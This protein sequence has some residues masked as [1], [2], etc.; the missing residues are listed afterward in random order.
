MEGSRGKGISKPA[1]TNMAR[2]SPSNTDENELILIVKIKK[3][4]E[5]VFVDFGF[6][7]SGGDVGP[8]SKSVRV[9]QLIAYHKQWES[10]S[11][12]DKTSSDSETEKKTSDS[13][14][15]SSSSDLGDNKEG[16]VDEIDSDTSDVNDRGHQQ[17]AT[18]PNA[19]ISIESE[20]C[21]EGI[22]EGEWTWDDGKN[23]P[24]KDKMSDV[25]EPVRKPV[26]KFQQL[27]YFWDKLQ[28]NY[29][30]GVVRG[31][32]IP[33]P[34]QRFVNR[35]RPSVWYAIEPEGSTNKRL[36]N[37]TVNECDM[38]PLEWALWD[39]AKR[40]GSDPSTC[41]PNNVS[42]RPNPYQIKPPLLPLDCVGIDT[43]S[44]LSV[45]SE[46]SD[47]PFLDESK[48][49][50]ESISLRG[51]GGEQSA[52]GGRGPMLI[53]ALD[54]Q[55]RLIYLV[56][57]LGVF[58][59]QSACVQLR[60]LGQQRMKTFGFNL[61]QNK[62]GDG[63]D[64]LVYT[65]V[66]GENRT[67][68]IIPLTTLDGILMLK[69]MTLEFTQRQQEMI[70]QHVKSICKNE[71]NGGIDYLFHFQKGK[72]CPV[73]I[74]NEGKLDDRERN[75]LDHWR[76]AHRS[77]TGARHDE[78]CPACEQAKHKTGSFKR[79][80]EYVGNGV[81]TLTV[82]WRLYCDGYGGQQSMGEES[83]QGAKG[84]F[85]FVCPVSG[86][87]K[88]KLY[89][90]SKQYPAILYQV[91]QEVESE[92][93]AVREIYVDTFIVNISKAAEDVAAMFKVR[94]I[95]ISSGTPQE[96]AYAERAVQTLAQMSRALMAGAPHLPQF[97]WG[98][99][100]LYAGYLHKVLPQKGK[101]M[102]SPYEMTTMRPPNLETM[103][104]KVFGCACQYEP[105]NGAE[106]KRAPKTLW[107]WFVGVQW[108]MVLILRPSDKKVISVSRKKVHCHE[109]CY[110]KFDPT[111]QPRPL[112]TFT[113][114]TLV[115]N[116]IDVAIDEATEMDKKT[117]KK[118]K[119]DHHIPA[120]VPSVKS[121]SD[122]N[123]NAILNEQPLEPRGNQ[124]VERQDQDGLQ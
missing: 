62:D 7:P 1:K 105:H 26:F 124:S 42:R 4:T 27:V 68:A 35:R 64:Y 117:L 52:V 77:I 86:S 92:G 34:Q 45:S 122:F 115:E 87:M 71:H 59:Q 97:M 2:R 48:E 96:L 28:A 90:T 80:S 51:I 10:D 31:I 104:I 66:S 100:D 106:H 67:E 8:F 11:E 9:E 15:E 21:V 83:Y 91:L 24:R 74:M 49:A 30:V 114:F 101:D 57:P 3:D 47:F 72:V 84:G 109:L 25:L 103:F 14:S 110:A 75:R 116:E 119:E 121:L 112:I 73:L 108:P 44:A 113:D 43:C 56:D 93:Y 95:P 41:L 63:M 123:R 111:T 69:T 107:G 12:S 23:P 39:M 78:R 79:N 6:H 55:G 60:I 16:K 22:E 29:W 20:A 53:S 19:P 5:K 99:S 102:K 40:R 89:A 37:L 118:F 50:Q 81:P 65:S 82:Y 120:H 38:R 36:P 88:V 13:E 85:I 33:N 98:C 61:V 94:I 17:V 32:R 18:N 46:R 58:L 54:D 70:I 76:F